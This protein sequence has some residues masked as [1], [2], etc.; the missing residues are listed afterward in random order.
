MSEILTEIVVP[1][2][3]ETQ[4]CERDTLLGVVVVPHIA[5]GAAHVP[6]LSHRGREVRRSV[7]WGFK[8][9]VPSVVD[10][11]RH[12]EIVETEG[13]EVVPLVLEVHIDDGLQNP[14][15]VDAIALCGEEHAP[16]DDLTD[17][18]S[19][20]VEMLEAV[21]KLIHARI[22]IY[23]LPTCEEVGLELVKSA[24]YLLAKIGMES[25]MEF[26]LDAITRDAG[27][28]EVAGVYEVFILVI[29]G[30]GCLG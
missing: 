8:F 25:G 5:C 19:R 1:F 12:T 14:R 15:A 13:K 23:R 21:E 26:H 7:I 2:T 18:Q 3:Y 11:F 4:G 28:E 6:E 22:G 29:C 16:I 30:V 9:Q 10:R 20:P 27:T 24:I 17:A